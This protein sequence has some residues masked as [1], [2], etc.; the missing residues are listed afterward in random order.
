L[1]LNNKQEVIGEYCH[2]QKEGGWCLLSN[3]QK[4]QEPATDPAQK[5]T[6]SKKMA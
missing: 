5:K 2:E 4:N 6:L 1:F 3:E